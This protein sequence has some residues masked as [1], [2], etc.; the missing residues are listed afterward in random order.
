M[1]IIVICNIYVSSTLI[2]TTISYKKGHILF[3]NLE[4][5]TFLFF[6]FIFLLSYTHLKNNTIRLFPLPEMIQLAKQPE[7]TLVLTQPSSDL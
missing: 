5:F 2:G 3:H 6:P 4:K 1:Q 7:N